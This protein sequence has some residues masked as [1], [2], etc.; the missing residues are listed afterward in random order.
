MSL[1]SFTFPTPAEAALAD[2]AEAAGQRLVAELSVVA[3]G[4]HTPLTALYGRV[5]RFADRG[6][7]SEVWFQPLAATPAR[8]L[9]VSAR[10][11]WASE[12]CWAASE[13]EGG[14][15]VLVVTAQVP[16]RFRSTARFD[17]MLVALVVDPAEAFTGPV[18]VVTG[19][20]PYGSSHGV[21]PE[22][23][24]LERLVAV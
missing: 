19:L 7:H 22:I 9:V 12:L 23:L 24:E 18:R 14:P 10:P 1:T 11:W 13:A 5:E 21:W 20:T 2:L 16:D 15:P 4:I 6:T 8:R 3:K 17:G